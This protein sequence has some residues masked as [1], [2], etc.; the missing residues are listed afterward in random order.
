MSAALFG[1]ASHFLCSSL[2]W[3]RCGTMSTENKVHVLFFCRNLGSS[4]T[5]HDKRP[6]DQDK[7]TDDF[8]MAFSENGEGKI[9]GAHFSFFQ[10]LPET[11]GR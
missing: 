6:F 10:Q 7:N 5:V 9:Y 3:L 4:Q 2:A 1:G 11:K 8:V